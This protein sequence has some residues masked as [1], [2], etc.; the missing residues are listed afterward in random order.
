MIGEEKILAFLSLINKLNGTVR[1]PILGA[2]V[3]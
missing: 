3:M 2:M 1:T